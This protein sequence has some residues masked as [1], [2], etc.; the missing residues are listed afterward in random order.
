MDDVVAATALNIVVANVAAPAVAGNV[1]VSA[2][3]AVVAVAVA[4]TITCQEKGS[5]ELAETIF[6]AHRAEKSHAESIPICVFSV[7]VGVSHS[8]RGRVQDEK[9]K[10]E[11]EARKVGRPHN[12][13]FR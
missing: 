4:N 10:K 7:I 13:F 2:D 8:T 6:Q 5:V 3:G 9:H 11:D 1:A 12:L